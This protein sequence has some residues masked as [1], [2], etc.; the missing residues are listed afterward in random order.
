MSAGVPVFVEQLTVHR[1][2]VN[3]KQNGDKD[4]AKSP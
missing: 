4:G 2:K 3:R 1:R